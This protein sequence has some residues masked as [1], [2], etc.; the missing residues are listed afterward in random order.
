MMTTS[1]AALRTYCDCLN[2]VKT[3]I[4]PTFGPDDDAT[5]KAVKEAF[6]DL[7]HATP[8]FGDYVTNELGAICGRVMWIS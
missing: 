3:I 7:Y 8:N 5:P 6:R 1:I 2:A 4:V